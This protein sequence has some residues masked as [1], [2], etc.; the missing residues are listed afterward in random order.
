MHQKHK[1]I[2]PCVLEHFYRISKMSKLSLRRTLRPLFEYVRIQCAAAP[3]NI[4]LGKCHTYANVAK[5]VKY[6]SAQVSFI[7]R[8]RRPPQICS[9]P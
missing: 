6:E 3:E 2:T 7:S 1:W 5:E 9:D 4:D 8:A